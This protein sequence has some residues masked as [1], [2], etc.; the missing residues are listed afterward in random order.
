MRQVIEGSC[1][2]DEIRYQTDQTTGPLGHCHCQMCRKVHGSA[3]SSIVA[4]PSSGFR[5]TSGESLLSKFESSPGKWRWFCSRCGSQL[6]STRDAVT[7]SLLLR[8]GCIDRGYSEPGV[9]HCWVD[10]K[11]S[12]HEITDPLPQFEQGF[13]SAP[14]GI[15]ES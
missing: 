15:D 1:L 7:D 9:A 14:T 2:C 5:W 11:A 13:P 3:F 10:S 8:A 12:W 4:S 6:I